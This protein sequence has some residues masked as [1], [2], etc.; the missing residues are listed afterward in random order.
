MSAQTA[1]V[2]THSQTTVSSTYIY[3]LYVFHSNYKLQY[4]DYSAAGPTKAG[5][6]KLSVLITDQTDGFIEPGTARVV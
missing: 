3:V 1:N 6:M 2:K 4:P 5:L